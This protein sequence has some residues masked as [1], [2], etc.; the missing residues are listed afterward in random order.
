LHSQNLARTLQVALLLLARQEL[1]AVP[2][3]G[4]TK[5]AFR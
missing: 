4:L 1:V 5:Q 3:S 2:S